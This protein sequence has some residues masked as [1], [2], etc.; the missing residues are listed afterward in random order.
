PRASLEYQSSNRLKEL[1]TPKIRNNIWSIQMCPGCPGQPRWQSP[2]H[3]PSGWQNLG[4]QPP[5][6]KSGT[7]CQ[8]LNPMCQTT[9][10]SFNWPCPR[11]SQTNAFLTVIPAGRCWTAPRRRW[12]ARGWSSWPSPRCARTSMRTTTPTA[13]PQPPWWHRRPHAST[14]LPPQR[15]SPRKCDTRP[16]PA[17]SKHPE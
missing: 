14:S 8:N 2:A 7:P 12:P 1:A 4:S 5:C 13:S 15:A 3:G 17:P 10:V 9:A 11:P 16:D 6:W